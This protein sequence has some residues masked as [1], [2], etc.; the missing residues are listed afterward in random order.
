MPRKSLFPP[1]SIEEALLLAQTIWQQNAGNP[2]RRI[3][4]FNALDRQP[5]SSTS[6]ALITASAGYGITDGSYKSDVIKLT[7]VGVAIMKEGD[8]TAKLNA[9][10][11][12][13]IFRAFYDRYRDAVI[14]G[15][16]AAMDFLRAQGIPEGNAASCLEV[17]LKNG[18]QVGLIQE[19]SG[20][21]RIIDPEHVRE[22]FLRRAQHPTDRM[23]Q[24]IADELERTP[25]AGQ[26][27]GFAS[28]S[29][30]DH[31][32]PMLHIDVQIHISADA[33][34]DQIDQIFAS[35]AKHLYGKGS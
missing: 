29:T 13:D 8:A 2:M 15:Q 24:P 3:T 22:E 26:A 34:P 33:K 19:I 18:R 21:E 27:P 12:V 6:R 35:M 14:P 9:V 1:N 28:A 16:A 30:Q 23:A 7:D 20:K 4:M 11:G 10:L 5:E 17:I 31:H 25:A 32:L